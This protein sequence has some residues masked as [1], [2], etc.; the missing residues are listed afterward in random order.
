MDRVTP[1][2]EGQLELGAVY[3]LTGQAEGLDMIPTQVF[4]L[5]SFDVSPHNGSRVLRGTLWWKVWIMG[6]WYSGTQTDHQVLCHNVSIG[7]GLTGRHDLHLER[8]DPR[9][10]IEV[11]GKGRAYGEYIQQTMEGET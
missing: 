3:Q 10:V 5:E 11:L 6:K 8:I 1:T 2:S 9:S 7:K 4:R